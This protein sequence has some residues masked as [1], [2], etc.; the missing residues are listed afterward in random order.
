MGKDKK[1]KAEVEEETEEQP[2]LLK[3]VMTI[4][5]DYQGEDIELDL[6]SSLRI[7]DDVDEEID[8]AAAD[9]QFINALLAH[10]MEEHEAAKDE[11]VVWEAERDE[12]A[13]EELSRPTEMKVHTEIRRNPKWLKKKNSLRK[14]HRL[15]NL[16]KGAAEAYKVKADMVR[17]KASNLRKEV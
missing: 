10:A 6:A 16:L 2:S 4:T 15:V 12:A 9:L 5:I 11:M 8:S 17:T 1:V 14:K 7:G 13:R 3:R